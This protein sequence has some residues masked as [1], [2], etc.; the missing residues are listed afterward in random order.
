LQQVL[1]AAAINDP[2]EPHSLSLINDRGMPQALRQGLN[3]VVMDLETRL[4][5]LSSWQG[6]MA[7]IFDG[8]GR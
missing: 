3:R 4:L 2:S 6:P 8:R 7:E 1:V 5:S